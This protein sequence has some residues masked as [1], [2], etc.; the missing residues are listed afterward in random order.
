MFEV[1]KNSSLFLKQSYFL[2][3]WK[4][5]LY[6]KAK[7]FLKLLIKILLHVYGKLFFKL[8]IKII[9]HIYAKLFLKL[10]KKNSSTSHVSLRPIWLDLWVEKQKTFFAKKNSFISIGKKSSFYRKALIIRTILA[11]LI[12]LF[13]NLLSWC[14]Y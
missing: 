2:N 13:Y 1:V 11:K 14:H 3:C 5:L 6:F 9:L 7:L 8:L 12:S 4:I 10:L